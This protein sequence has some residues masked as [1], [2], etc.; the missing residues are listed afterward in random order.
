MIYI[1]RGVISL[2]YADDTLLFLNNDLEK[3]CHLKWFMACFEHLLGMKNNYHKSNMTTINLDEGEINQF[4]K[5]FCCKIETFPFKCLG[6]TLHHD[7]LRREDIQNVVDSV[8]NRISGW[9]GRLLSY[10]ATLTFLK[11]YLAS[12]PIYLMYVIKFLKL[13][14]DIINSHMAIWGGGG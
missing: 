10:S 6:V 12:I 14:V 9:R 7:K 3:A 2:Q 11:A 5:V 1:Q 4:A 13:D 8:I